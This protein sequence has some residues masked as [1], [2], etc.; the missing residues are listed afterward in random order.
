[1]SK[2]VLH[3]YAD[4]SI[5][6]ALR[7]ISETAHNSFKETKL[8]RESIGGINYHQEECSAMPVTARIR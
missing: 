2:I 8:I 1:M 4:I 3:V 6:G 7:V 5:N